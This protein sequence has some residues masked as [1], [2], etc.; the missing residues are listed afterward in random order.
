MS[1]KRTIE[2]KDRMYLL[3]N[4]NMEND[5]KICKL[6][7]WGPYR[8]ISLR[9]IKNSN[10]RF[11]PNS[12]YKHMLGNKWDIVFRGELDIG[13]IDIKKI[14]DKF[15]ENSHK[16]EPRKK[17]ERRYE[18]HER[19]TQKEYTRRM[20]NQIEQTTEYETE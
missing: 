12:Q 5:F 19:E 2:I 8:M 1:N 4:I 9:E 3:K 15:I 14:L 11:D 13:Y 18:K 7:S 20:A 10:Y 6:K 16:S 17:K